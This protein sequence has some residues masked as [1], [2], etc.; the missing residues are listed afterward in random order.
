MTHL[1]SANIP[2][3]DSTVER[4]KGEYDF[5]QIESNKK[6]ACKRGKGVSWLFCNVRRDALRSAGIRSAGS[7][8]MHLWK[9]GMKVMAVLGVDL[10][11]G[12]P[13]GGVRSAVVSR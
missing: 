13:D 4:N 5:C 9:Y 6:V 1:P 12:K 10:G 8:N 2:A 7:T 3:R 11:K